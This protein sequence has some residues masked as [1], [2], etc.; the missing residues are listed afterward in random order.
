[1]N[2]LIFTNCNKTFLVLLTIFLNPYLFANQVTVEPGDGKFFNP[3]EL[4]N[5]KD[6]SNIAVVKWLAFGSGCRTVEEVASK[7]RDVDFDITPRNS[8]NIIKLKFDLS[9][10]HF[11]LASGRQIEK[12]SMIEMYSECALRFA[13]KGQAGRRVKRIEGSSEMKIQK[14]KGSS[15]LVINELRFGQFGSDEKKV[16]Y[17]K[18]IEVKSINLDLQLSKDLVMNTLEGRSSCGTDQILNYDFTLFAKKPAKDSQVNV[19]FT[20][21]KKAFIR[22]EYEDCQN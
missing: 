13:I 15:L 7:D 4:V 2:S 16:E 20:S 9:F 5:D 10:P 18:D 8:V 12:D 11:G 19:S 14:E 17:D 3:I 1:M 6:D 22:L 21:P